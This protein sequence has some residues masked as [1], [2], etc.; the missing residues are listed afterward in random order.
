MNFVLGVIMCPVILMVNKTDLDWTYTDKEYVFYTASR[1]PE[2]YKD[3]PCLKQFIKTDFQTY[4]P[5][6]GKAVQ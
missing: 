3:A 6:C 5:I 4:R 1:C 2:I